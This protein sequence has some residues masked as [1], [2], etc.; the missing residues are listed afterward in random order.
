MDISVVIVNWNTKDFLEEA[1]R[2]V[3]FNADGLNLDIIIV[4]NGSTD[5]S[6]DML[7]QKYPQVCVFPNS[8]NVGFAKAN[9]QAADV[10]N[11]EFLVLLN[12]DATLKPGA[13]KALTDLYLTKPGAGI[14]G[15]TI[16]NLDGSLQ[17]TYADFP[18]LGREFLILSG[19]GRLIFGSIY[20]SHTIKTQQMAIPVDYVVGACLLIRREAFEDIGGF[21]ENY[22]M[23]AEEVDL[24]FRMKRKGWEVWYQ[25][26]AEIYHRGAGS[27]VHLP[28]KRELDLYRSRVQFAMKYHGL[29]T[30]WILAILMVIFTWL[31][32]YFHKG[33]RFFT[34]GKRGRVVLEPHQL[35]S[36]LRRIL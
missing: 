33:L 30:A 22:F 12:S 34:R 24:C 7:A 9:N 16:L 2:S 13:L 15:G 25:P 19:L 35:A 11:G 28:V 4:D 5:G 18:T 29:E 8:E 27:S 1:I 31:K 21:D 20:P 3:L 17:G 23:Y 36:E 26:Q 32:K 6:L 10:T 14:V